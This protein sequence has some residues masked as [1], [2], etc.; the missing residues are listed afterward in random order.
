MSEG[1]DIVGIEQFVRLARAG[2]RPGASSQ[3]K[4]AA[5]LARVIHEI[6]DDFMAMD[7]DAIGGAGALMQAMAGPFTSEQEEKQIRAFVTEAVCE[8]GMKGNVA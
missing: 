8:A 4:A 6:G 7:Y 1:I 2:A 5:K 3:E